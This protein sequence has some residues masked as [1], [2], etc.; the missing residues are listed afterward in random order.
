LETGIEIRP[1]SPG[2]AEDIQRIARAAWSD[3]Y[4]DIILPQNRERLLATWYAPEALRDSIRQANS[5]FFVALADGRP[6][7][8]AQLVIRTDGVAQLTRIY[9]LPA[10][11][12]RAVGTFL[13]RAC[14]AQLAE[15][16]ARNLIVEVEKDNQVG[17][18]FYAKSGFLFSRERTMELPGQQLL[19]QELVLPLSVGEGG[20]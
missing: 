8:F 19:L 2:D 3:T 17:K 16:G 12:R 1:A 11:Q 10:W 6:V 20:G 7:G 13:L 4:A 9:V 15:T 18:A 5:W 14:L